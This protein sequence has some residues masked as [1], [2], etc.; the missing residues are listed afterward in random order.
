M[1]GFTKD[2]LAEWLARIMGFLR[3]AGPSFA[4]VGGASVL[5]Y[6][7]RARTRDV[8]VLVVTTDEVWADL[9]QL[10][11]AHGLRPERK[12]PWHWRLWSEPMYADLLRAEVP[13]QVEAVLAAKLHDFAGIAVPVAPPEH[14]VALKVVAGRP[15]DLRDVGEIAERVPDLDRQEVR[16]LLAPFD[17]DWPVPGD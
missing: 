6:G 7:R 2:D 1:T 4:L 16:R 10:A 17:L 14:V 8:D 3:A 13:L 15:G 12:G 11:L 5:L 9:D